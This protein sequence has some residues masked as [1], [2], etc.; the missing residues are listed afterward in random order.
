VSGEVILYQTEDGQTR[1]QCRFD[2][3]TI[4]M[5][6]VQIAELFQTSAAEHQ[7]S[8]EGDLHRGRAG[9]HGNH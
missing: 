3:G 2:E 9:R 4:W 5:T 6:Q 1:V 8:P 7:H